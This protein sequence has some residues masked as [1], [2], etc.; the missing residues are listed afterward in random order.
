MN[1]DRK[2]QF[3][4]K[5]P[6]VGHMSAVPR[7]SLDITPQWVL[8]SSPNRALRPSFFHICP[9]RCIEQ[10]VRTDGLMLVRGSGRTKQCVKKARSY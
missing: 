1:N 10:G 8:I 7:V 5:K 4:D 9:I 6:P 3:M 2:K